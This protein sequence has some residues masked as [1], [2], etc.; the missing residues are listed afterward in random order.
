MNFKR[1]LVLLLSALILFT[2]V[3]SAAAEETGEAEPAALPGLAPAELVNAAWGN[4]KLNVRRWQTS[5][6]AFVIALCRDA[7]SPLKCYN[8]L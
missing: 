4:C 3:P 5:R 7:R 1:G 8:F 2:L 6:A